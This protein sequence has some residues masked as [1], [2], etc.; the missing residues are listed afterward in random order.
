MAAKITQRQ[1][2]F[3]SFI[4]R[5]TERYGVSPSFDEL[6]AYFGITSPSVNGMIKTLE[7]NG[8]I[9]RIPGAARTLRVEVPANLLPS[10]DFGHGTNHSQSQQCQ[11][12]PH[13]TVAFSGATAVLD[14]L[15][16]MMSESTLTEHQIGHA[17]L[18]SAKCA[19]EKLTAAGLS[20][21]EA[22]AARR[23]IES[24]ISRWQPNANIRSRRYCRRR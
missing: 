11:E 22:L 2:Q 8:F 24:E 13:S 10:I 4:L 12:L 23:L 17:I 20:P 5:F 16:P 7:R 15:L 18:R 1:G 3:L 9:S 21:D 19:Y 6:A 14:T